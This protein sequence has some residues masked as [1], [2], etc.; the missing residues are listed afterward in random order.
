MFNE[1]LSTVEFTNHIMS[2]WISV[3][4]KM[5]CLDFEC[6]DSDLFIMAVDFSASKHISWDE[7]KKTLDVNTLEFWIGGEFS[8]YGTRY[9]NNTLMAKDLEGNVYTFSKFYGLDVWNADFVEE[10]EKLGC[11][12]LIKKQDKDNA[13]ETEHNLADLLNQSRDLASGE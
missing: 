7:A 13:L 2:M 3:P 9:H 11:I 6:N 4:N 8:N 5:K 10:F 1:N 12:A